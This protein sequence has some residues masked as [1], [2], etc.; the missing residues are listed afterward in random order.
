MRTHTVILSLMAALVLAGCA[1][2]PPPG[3]PGEPVTHDTACNVE[4]NGK[5]VS[6]A[7]YPLLSELIYV[8]DDFSVD[9]F[10]QPEGGGKSVSVYLTVGTGPNRAE[11]LPE[12]FGDEDLVIHTKDNYVISTGAR[13]RVHGTLSAVEATEGEITC[14]INAIDLIETAPE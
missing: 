3:P 7:G 5:R 11:D 1:P 6:L 9:L 8:T 4:N 2:P 10:E 12:D 13:I 14:F